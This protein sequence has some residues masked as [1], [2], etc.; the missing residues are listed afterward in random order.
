MMPGDAVF[1]FQ[2]NIDFHPTRRKF[3]TE[4]RNGPWQ[5]V[6]TPARNW[7]T[8]TDRAMFPLR[9]L[10]P[11]E[12]DGLLGAGKNIGVSSVVQS[13][14]RLHGQMMLCGQACATVAAMCLR[15][16]IEAARGRRG[17]CRVCA[18]SSARS[19]TAAAGRAC[20]SGRITT[21]RRNIRRS[22]PRI[23]SPSPESGARMRTAS[24][25]QPEKRL[26][27]GEWDAVN[28]GHPNPCGR[29]CTASR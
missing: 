19:C 16:S 5:Y 3:L 20:C 26:I 8:D 11:V 22:R 14:L 18:R 25:F 6:H 13:A 27:D 29:C 24:F 2:F 7:H 9:G 17:C 4:D 10:V 12:M 28:A 1:G 21:C 23:F 15:D